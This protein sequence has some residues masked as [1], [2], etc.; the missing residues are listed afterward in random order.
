[1]KRTYYVTV[2]RAGKSWQAVCPSL[3]DYG[4]VMGGE[5]RE[6]ALT[7][8]ESAIPM[9]LTDIEKDGGTPPPDE[10]FHGGIPITVDT[11]E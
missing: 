4:A 8:V 6:E 9:I 5:S 2:S 11:A 1:M 3:R 10:A 7:H